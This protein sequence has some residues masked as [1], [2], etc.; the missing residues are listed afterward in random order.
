MK[1]NYKINCLIFILLHNIFYCIGQQNEVSYIPTTVPLAP[2]AASLGIYGSMPVGHYNGLPNI[3][4]PLYEIDLDGKKIPIS[5]S[6]HASGV[7]VAQD[8]SW[9]G[10]GW[11]LNAGGCITH[12]TV[13][14]DDFGYYNNYMTGF[15]FNHIYP[16]KEDTSLYSEMNPNLYATPEEQARVEAMNQRI[17]AGN[18]D[19][20]PDFFYYNFSNYSGSMFF[21]KADSIPSSN[22]YSPKAILKNPKEYLDITVSIESG[23]HSTSWI[24]IDGDGYKYYFGGS[25]NSRDV[26]VNYSDVR[27]NANGY[28][29]TIDEVTEDPVIYGANNRKS[30]TAWYLDS[31][32]SPLNN[33]VVF[34]YRKDYIVTPFS[35]SETRS[36]RSSRIMNALGGDYEE[37]MRSLYIQNNYSY[38]A[39]QE[40]L[41]DKITFPSGEINF[42]TIADR[43]DLYM[44]DV[45]EYAQKLVKLDIKNNTDILKS[46]NFNY[47]YQGDQTSYK[48]CRLMLKEVFESNGNQIKPPHSFTYYHPELLPPKYSK[49]IDYWGFYNAR[50]N[51]HG[52]GGLNQYY[53]AEPNKGTL[54][55][56]TIIY[57]NNPPTTINDIYTLARYNGKGASIMFGADRSPNQESMKYGV[58]TSIKYPTGGKTEFTYVPHT[59]DNK[60]ESGIEKASITNINNVSM[61]NVGTEVRYFELDKDALVYYNVSLESSSPVFN[62]G[63]IAYLVIEDSYEYENEVGPLFSYSEC[64]DCNLYGLCKLIYPFPNFVYNTNK[65]STPDFTYVNLKEGKYRIYVVVNP[66]F[67]NAGY[68]VSVDLGEIRKKTIDF[69]SGLRVKEI[70]DISSDKSMVTKKFNYKD[71]KLTL[72]PRHFKEY[73]TSGIGYPSFPA[74]TTIPIGANYILGTSHPLS[75][76]PQ[77]LMVD[78]QSEVGYSQVEEVTGNDN[79]KTVYSFYN[80]IETYVNYIANRRGT[81]LKIAYYPQGANDNQPAKTIDY[82]YDNILMPFPYTIT[83][84]HVLELPYHRTYQGIESYVEIYFYDIP[85]YWLK[86]TNEKITEY[87]NGGSIVTNKEYQYNS[88]NYLPEKIITTNNQGS[89]ILEQRIKYPY[90]CGNTSMT[91]K[92]L[93]NIPIETISLKNNMVVAAKKTEYTELL[94]TYLPNSIYTLNTTTPVSLN[95]YT[96][97]YGPAVFFDRYTPNGKYRELRGKDGIP[98]VYLW[99]YNGQYPI[100]EVKNATYDNVV[101]AVNSGFLQ[102][103]TSATVPSDGMIASLGNTLR[104]ELPDAFVTV[105]TYKPL[106]GMTSATDP[107]GISTYYEYDSF[108]RLKE[109]YIIENNAK[110]ILQKYDYHYTNQQ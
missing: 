104:T 7:K 6:Y 42:Q 91:N 109:T 100:A 58:L 31:I 52:W 62:T 90:S 28:M 101:G 1:T 4:I 54:I 32:V 55:P 27:S 88:N 69:G 83:G 103:I 57:G 40:T 33:K 93:V 98:I 96:S 34:T 29:T 56:T 80:I 75:P 44:G 23:Y 5:L 70:K 87:T 15:Y 10:L 107:R 85:S 46:Y 64:I 95:N 49:N 9:V 94:D 76:D 47:E 24:V 82:L 97:M 81:P 35:L 67:T 77:D 89:P 19:L 22:R 37:F 105:Y 65:T 20:Q 74:G 30:I 78:L 21:P 108:N 2:T 14:G 12:K 3:T 71:G 43:K 106:V 66:A 50:T 13:H 63:N 110:R 39:I 92:H 61:Q 48:T 25:D 72:M 60:F 26:N 17:A 8:A 73:M 68:S 59:F 84:W 45:P 99:S 36:F 18:I 102:M 51:N 53:P 16:R 86:L 11:A 38:S 41:L 79:G